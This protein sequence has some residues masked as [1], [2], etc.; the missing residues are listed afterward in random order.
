MLIYNFQKEFIGID[1]KD[2]KTLGFKNLGELRTEVTDFADLFVKTPGFIHNFKHV[3][4]I[5]FITCADSNEESKV[6]INVNNKNYRC[7]IQ[8]S[9]AY[10]IDNPTSKSFIINLHNLRELSHKESESIAG[11]IIQREAPV[12]TQAAKQ[13]FNTPEHSDSFEEE[14]SQEQ[15]IETPSS[16]EALVVDDYDAPLEID[17]SEEDEVLLTVD[18]FDDDLVTPQHENGIQEDL[19]APLEISFDDDLDDD[20]M[21]DVSSDVHEIS[22]VEPLTQTVQ[23]SFENGYVYDPSVASEELGLPL[24]LIEEFIQDFIEQA[25]EFKD[26]LYNAVEEGNF[27]NLKILSHKLKGVAANLRIEDALEALT[28]ANTSSDFNEITISLDTLYNIVAKLAGEEINVEKEIVPEIQ[29]DA[30]LD[31][32][33]KE[34]EEEEEDLYSDPIEVEDYQVPEKIEIPELADDTFLAVPDVTTLEIEDD[35]LD[36][37]LDL[38]EE[39]T[40][41]IEEDEE[42]TL[43]IEEDTLEDEELTLDLSEEIVED[44]IPTAINIEYSKESVASEIGL[45]IESFNELFGDFTRESNALITSMTQAVEKEDFSLCSSEAVK[46]KG[47]SDNMRITGYENELETLIHSQDSD[48]ISTALKTVDAI[49]AQLSK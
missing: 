36:L 49:L 10:L 20:L 16:S 14:I 37:S 43:D 1:E 31:L 12:A 6:I 35:E 18:D 27:D 8:I 5:D 26:D 9:T 3:H 46:L 24:D 13:I 2:L 30:P 44:E 38:D 28:T 22:T 21:L 23:E 34:E 39:I 42:I 4:W 47:M 7:I 33:F 40:L 15:E 32:D 45:E 11:D 25:K 48:E 17:I 41:D 19:Q 29:E